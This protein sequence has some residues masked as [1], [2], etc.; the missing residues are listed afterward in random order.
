MHNPWR[1]IHR[2][3][4]TDMMGTGYPASV[5]GSAPASFDNF[6]GGDS[7]KGGPVNEANNNSGAL[8]DLL[9]QPEKFSTVTAPL[10]AKYLPSHPG[11]YHV[12]PAARRASSQ[13]GFHGNGGHWAFNK[14][15]NE[16]FLKVNF[17]S[18]HQ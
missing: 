11:E 14:S 7:A 1:G 13:N 12:D 4:D 10:Y 2:R 17:M 5:S 16:G 15:P 8:Y 3:S 6:L 9:K 18:E